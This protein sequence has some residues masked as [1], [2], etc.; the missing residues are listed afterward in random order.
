MSGSPKA[1]Q[2]L[3]TE[4]FKRIW[5]ISS[6]FERTLCPGLSQTPEADEDVSAKLGKIA[7]SLSQEGGVDQ[8]ISSASFPTLQR[9]CSE[10]KRC[11][12]ADTRKNVVF[13]TGSLNPLVMVVGEGPGCNEDLQGLPFVGDAGRFL[14]KWLAA[15]HLSRQKNVY[16]CN[17]IKCRPPG[18]RDPHEDEVA[19]CQDYLVQQISLLKPKAILGLGKFA[20]QFLFDSDKRISELRG[21]F[22]IY[23]GI[24]VICTYHPAAV[25]RNISLKR[26]V[27]EDLQ[28]LASFLGIAIR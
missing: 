15:I 2:R 6:D 13:G 20:A 23:R 4:A 17:V 7:G 12:L 24:P 5:D 22:T 27:W 19:S 11:R 8:E 26:S 28:K 3:L 14:D 10:C 18:N 16:I 9:I 21:S 1:R 25:L